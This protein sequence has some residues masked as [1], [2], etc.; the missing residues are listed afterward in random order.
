MF[1]IGILV[2][3]FCLFSSASNGAVRN[4]TADDSPTENC[5]DIDPSE[6]CYATYWPTPTA[7]VADSAMNQGC[8]GCRVRT[9]RSEDSSVTMK[10]CVSVREAAKCYCSG[11]GS[12]CQETGTCTYR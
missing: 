3:T 2:V 11:S 5:G 4:Q 10:F 6:P 12:D 9:F 8:R 1:R 7:C